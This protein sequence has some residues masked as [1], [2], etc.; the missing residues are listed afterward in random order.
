MGSDSTAGDALL[1]DIGEYQIHA[2]I[3]KMVNVDGNRSIGDDCA[4]YPVSD[5]STL[6]INV[7]RL[8]L[9]VEPYMRARLSVAQTLSDIICMGG[10]PQ[11][12]LVSLT[13]PRDT[14]VATLE[15][16]TS[17]I[18]A[19]LAMYGATLAGGDTKEGPDFWMVGVG[20]GTCSPGSLVRRTGGR[21]GMAIGV[22]SAMGVP[23]GRAWANAVINE[24]NL[25]VPSELASRYQRANYDLRLPYDESRAVI[26]TGG[27]AAG[28]DLSDG[29]GGGLRILSRA[30]DVGFSIN[31][32]TL[33][34]LIDPEL[35]PVAQALDIPLECLTLSPGYIWENLYAIDYAFAEQA[36]LAAEAAGGKFTVIG[37][38][39]ADQ[40]ISFDG[41]QL[42]WSQIPA[43]E[44]F[45]KK[46]AWRDRFPVWQRMCQQAFGRYN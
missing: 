6:L 2:L 45:A 41:S 9:D 18:Q 30:S 11:K 8:A 21:P 12:Y 35:A 32:T 44:K 37:S 7:D 20:L 4:I 17:A 33:R 10:Q 38:T 19:D 34:E 39:T 40:K 23:W 36:S 13:L 25:D 24:L 29:L 3:E 46:Y 42:D 5:D 28:L 1:T 15:A 14:K 27:V 43:D 16:L 22:T 26:A 31:R